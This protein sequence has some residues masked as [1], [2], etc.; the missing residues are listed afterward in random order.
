[1]RELH[2]QYPAYGFDAHKGYASACHLQAL[3]E[4]GPCP[5]HR[6]SFAP[7]RE[8]CGA[9]VQGDLLAVATG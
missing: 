8:A 4:H 2:A 9:P 6:R 7:V 3:R 5:Q 1:M